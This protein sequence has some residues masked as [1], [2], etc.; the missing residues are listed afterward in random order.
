MVGTR[1]VRCAF[2]S[3]GHSSEKCTVV[4]EVSARYAIVSKERLCFK[5]LGSKH[6][7]R[8]CKSKG[9]H[10]TCKSPRHHS[11]LYQNTSEASKSDAPKE[12]EPSHPKPKVNG[13]GE[14][15]V[16]VPC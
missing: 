9:K 10:S 1:E 8:S 15:I 3:G 12:V 11:A 4:S 5:C 13:A 2:C 16:K 7:S 14:D 6:N